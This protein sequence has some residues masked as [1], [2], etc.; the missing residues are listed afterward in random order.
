MITLQARLQIENKEDLEKLYDLMRR[1]CSAYRYAYNRLLEKK[2]ENDVRKEIQNLFNI[3]S[4]YAQSAIWEAKALIKSC[5]ERG[6]NPKKVIFGGRLL[7]EKLSKKHLTGKR[8]EK[9]KE[10]WKEKRQKVLYT[11]GGRYKKGNANLRLVKNN[12]D[13]YLRINV[14]KKE[15]IYAKIIRKVKREKD[16]WIDFIWNLEIAENSEGSYAERYFPYTVRVFSK[17]GKLYAHI[18]YEEKVPEKL[19]ITKENGIIGIDVN[20]SPFHLALA[21][22]SKDGN[23]LSY[24]KI[25]LHELINANKNKRKYLE[26]LIAHKVINYALENNKAIAIEKL[27]GLKNEKRGSGKA[28]L[29]KRL[30]QFC[31]RNILEK[32]KTLAEREGIEIIEVNPF[33]TSV[34]GKLKYSPIY[35]IDKDT[36]AAFVIAR[37]ALGFREEIP[38]N[39]EKLINDEDYLSYAITELEEKVEE[40]KEKKNKEKNKYKRNAIKTELK[41]LRN[42]LN[43]LKKHLKN[44]K[45]GKREPATQQPVNLGKKQVRGKLS[46]LL[47]SWRVLSAALTVPYLEKFLQVNG[48]CRD[49]S[50]LKKLL[51]KGDWIRAVSRLAPDSGQGRNFYKFGKQLNIFEELVS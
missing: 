1:Y 31:Y 46:G 45:S 33:Y 21:T 29:R 28:K 50:P 4:Q 5:K 6:Q 40:I 26:W 48:T 20:A 27:E 7:F 22:S 38:K 19:K 13:W 9:I 44:L 24:K 36:A 11:V 25:S 49:F 47:K 15:W 17:N 16:K 42:E 23:L 8:R 32:I 43:L 14:G 12:D 37:R 3:N 39:Y 10:K 34:I 30:Q 41:K 51:I 18:S 2:N 35:N